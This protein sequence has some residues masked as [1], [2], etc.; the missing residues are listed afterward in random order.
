V[1]T[2]S[3]ILVY[4]SIAFIVLCILLSIIIH[5]SNFEFRDGGETF[6][7][8]LIFGVPISLLMT[9]LSL[10]YTRYDSVINGIQI[11]VTILVS[12]A[13]FLVYGLMLATDWCSYTE[14]DIQFIHKND[15]NKVIAE[16]DFGCGAVDSTPPSETHWIME[17]YPFGLI[18]A[19]R[20][21]TSSID[22][23]QWDQVQ[24][25]QK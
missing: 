12:F 5:H 4:S 23:S 18:H 20:V 3:K 14:P 6:D 17:E 22:F 16:R 9:L 19:E 13:F 21:D 1:K 24:N 11:G 25:T 10:S 15:S 2:I 7:L 8:V